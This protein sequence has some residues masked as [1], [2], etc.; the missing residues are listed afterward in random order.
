MISFNKE[1]VFNLKPIDV[2]EV[3]GEVDG[4]LLEDEEQHFFTLRLVYEGNTLVEQ[5]LKVYD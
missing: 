4:L 2:K 3:I 1:S 5:S